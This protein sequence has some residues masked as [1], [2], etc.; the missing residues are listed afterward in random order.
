MKKPVE[1]LEKGQSSPQERKGCG[2]SSHIPHSFASFLIFPIL[3]FLSS[4]IVYQTDLST[5]TANISMDGS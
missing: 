4:L 3:I 5:M 1:G 2:K